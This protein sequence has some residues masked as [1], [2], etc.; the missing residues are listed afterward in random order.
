MT[1]ITWERKCQYSMLLAA[2]F[3]FLHE[4]S[5]MAPHEETNKLTLSN[6]VW[7][8]SLKLYDASLLNT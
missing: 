8:P 7:M 1:I 3:I 4:S 6:Q 5:V 2:I